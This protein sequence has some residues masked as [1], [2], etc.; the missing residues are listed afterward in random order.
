MCAPTHQAQSTD[1]HQPQVPVRPKSICMPHCDVYI[2]DPFDVDISKEDAE[3]YKKY[4]TEQLEPILNIHCVTYLTPRHEQYPLSGPLYELIEEASAHCTKILFPL[5]PALAGRTTDTVFR[6]Y[7]DKII[8]LKVRTDCLQHFRHIVDNNIYTAECTTE[9][10]IH[11][12][13]NKLRIQLGKDLSPNRYEEGQSSIPGTVQHSVPAPSVC[14][15]PASRLQ[16]RASLSST[17]HNMHVQR[18]RSKSDYILERPTTLQPQPSALP[19]EQSASVRQWSFEDHEANS[20]QAGASVRRSSQSR[21]SAGQDRRKRHG[22]TFCPSPQEG[23]EDQL[24]AMTI[25][26]PE[27]RRIQDKPKPAGMYRVLI[28]TFLNVFSTINSF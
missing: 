14:A 13:A 22:S 6:P 23:L 1:R 3:E 5:L 11:V 17:D 24:S 20:P 19:P 16:Q 7:R 21:L 10:E 9:K 28:C 2:P 8:F 15:T 26:D 18:S 4:V 25:V 27:K 12:V